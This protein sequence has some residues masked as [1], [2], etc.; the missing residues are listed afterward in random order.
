MFLINVHKFDIVFAQSVSLA[1][2]EHQVD[3]VGS[4]L[5]LEG[6][7]IFVLRR[8]QDLR[9]GGQIDAKGKVPI[10]AEGREAFGF[11]YHGDKRNMGV[12]HGLEC[13]A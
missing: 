9:Q 7:N 13:D 11:E 10:A 6:E 1:A 2:L 8:F 12:V 5:G 3:D 4:V